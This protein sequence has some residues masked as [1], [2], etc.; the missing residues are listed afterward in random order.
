MLNNLGRLPWLRVGVSLALATL[1][2]F[3]AVW[4][5]FWFYGKPSTLTSIKA[6]SELVTFDVFNP[7]L[8]IIHAQGLRIGS[9]PDA[10]RDD[11]CGAGAF[12][13]GVGAKVTYQRVEQ[14]A[15]QITI[16]GAGELRTPAGGTVPFEGELLLFH[17]ASCQPGLLANRLPVWGPGKIGS[18]FSMR[19][20]G[21]GPILLSA[22]LDVFGRTIDVPF[23]GK[24][25]SIYVAIEE[26]A[27]PPGSFIESDRPLDGANEELALNPEGAMFGFVELSGEPGLSVFVSTESRQLGVTTP[28]ARANSSR[29]DLG[30]FVQVLN[31]PG[32]LKIQL[33]FALLLLLA[34]KLTSAV[35][36]V[37][38]PHRRNR[39]RQRS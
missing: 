13:P 21:P 10:S 9:W 5:L 39:S 24:S 16:E 17:D 33:S 11:Q 36:L 26:M 18:P 2:A 35:D 19:S 20:D 30:L 7:E 27:I 28:G 25:G 14:G 38:P 34:P 3:G 1:L 4:G 15:L 31:D 32:F 37:F 23:F 6:R 8:A 22:T 29:I 12:L